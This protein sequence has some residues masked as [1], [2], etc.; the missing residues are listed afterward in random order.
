MIYTIASHFY[1]P[2]Y[3]FI[4]I[5]ERTRRRKKE[6]K[7][8]LERIR[9]DWRQKEVELRRP[10]ERVR[11]RWLRWRLLISHKRARPRVIRYRNA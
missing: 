9:R 5:P 11:R 4:S 6:W 1:Y 8:F 3:Y 7:R 2:D 10:L